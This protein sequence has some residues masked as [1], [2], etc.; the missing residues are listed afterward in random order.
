M[1]ILRRKPRRWFWNEPPVILPPLDVTETV[2][3]RRALRR[4]L[5]LLCLA[6][7]AVIFGGWILAAII[8]GALHGMGVAP[9]AWLA[10][11]AV[12]VPWCLGWLW[13]SYAAPRWRLWAMGH[14]AY[15]PQV[16]AVAVAGGYL[17]RDGHLFERTELTTPELRQRRQVLEQ[18]W[19]AA[20]A[21]HANRVATPPHD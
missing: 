17:W 15:W 4:G 3:P 5:G 1:P 14:C 2:S 11:P 13:W 21:R 19:R 8:A 20:I 16:R 9:P 6:P 18:A 7:M 12:A 10:V